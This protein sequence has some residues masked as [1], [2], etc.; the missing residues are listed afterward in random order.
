MP[1]SPWLTI[2][3]HAWC[4]EIHF[5]LPHLLANEIKAG[6]LK[7]SVEEAGGKKARA[8]RQRSMLKRPSL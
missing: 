5:L 1:I 6:W 4:R 3:V 8:K 2:Q 7:M